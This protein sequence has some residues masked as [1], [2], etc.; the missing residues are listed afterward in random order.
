MAY[1][2][3]CVE[4][5]ASRLDYISP[6]YKELLELLW[7]FTETKDYGA[8]N[9][10]A[11]SDKWGDY[12]NYGMWMGT[13]HTQGNLISK[14]DPFADVPEALVGMMGLCALIGESHLYGAF[15]SDN[16]KAYLEKM[17]AIMD[18]QDAPLPPMDR[19]QKNSLENAG[20]GDE[21]GFPAPRSFYMGTLE[22]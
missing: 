1:S 19:F 15:Q 12:Y 4:S 7:S 22:N 16:S 17:L 10:I 18:A 9:R 21:M 20:K 3:A 5:L 2:L 11:L 13:D 6:K 14:T 8:W